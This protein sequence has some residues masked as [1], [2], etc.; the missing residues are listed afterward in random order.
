M[1]GYSTDAV[2]TYGGASSPYTDS[3]ATLGAASRR[4]IV[5]YMGA[6][7]GSQPTCDATT[8]GGTMTIFATNGNSDT[9]QVCM[10]AAADSYAW[11]TVF[12]AP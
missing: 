10:K 12:T 4:W 2:T 1:V 9:F 6:A 7:V 3:T 8:R 5:G 11:R